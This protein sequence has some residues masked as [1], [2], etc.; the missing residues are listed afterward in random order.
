M[1]GIEIVGLILGIIPL[2]M[3][4]LEHYSQTVRV[5]KSV[6][7]PQDFEQ[8]RRQL[9]IEYGI[10]KNTLEKILS[11]CVTEK[12]LA[13][14]LEKPGGEAWKNEE[15]ARALQRRLQESFVVF[16][17]TITSMHRA[18]EDFRERLKLGS[19]GKV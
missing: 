19:D 10:Y 2:V 7:D 8:L 13:L 17:E 18:L 12:L 14:M 3:T 1:S 15:T 6:Y 5:V 11:G 9:R 16:I 4:G